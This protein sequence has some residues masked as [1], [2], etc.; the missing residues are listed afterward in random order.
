M[1]HGWHGSILC[2]QGAG[3][4][5]AS[6]QDLATSHFSVLVKHLDNRLNC[7]TVQQQE[8]CN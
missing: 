1:I 3:D 6:S 4:I 5:A 8:Q 7:R 2:L